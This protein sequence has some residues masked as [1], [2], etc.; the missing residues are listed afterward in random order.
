MINQLL[1]KNCIINCNFFYGEDW[2]KYRKY[3]WE[4]EKKF[5]K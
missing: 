4:V 3:F 2:I 1:I 5:L